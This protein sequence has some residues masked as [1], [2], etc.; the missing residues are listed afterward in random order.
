MN[1][2]SGLLTRLR[3]CL[4]DEKGQALPLCGLGVVAILGFTA[5]AIDV[6]QLRVEKQ[7]MQAA[8]DA[9]ALAGALE[10]SSCGSTTDCTAMTAA[11]KQAVTEN[12]LTVATA[13]TQC[14]GSASGL[15]LWVN[16]GPCELGSSSADPNYGSSKYVEAQL[17]NQVNTVFAGL[18]GFRTMTITVRAEASGA[19]ANYCLIATAD[20]ASPTQGIT[21]QGGSSGGINA[22]NCGIYDDDSSGSN[23]LVDNSGTVTS[24]K[25]MVVGGIQNSGATLSPKP[26]TGASNYADPLS[27]LSSDTPSAGSCTSQSS[28]PA[29]GAALTPG[30]FCSVI[31]LNSNV[32][33][34]L[35]AGTYYLKN[36]INVDSGA[37]LVGTAGVT[38]Y[39]ATGQLNFNSNS[40]VQLTAPTSGT[41]SGIA[42]WQPSSDTNEINLD[43]GSTSAYNGA[44]YAPTAELTLNSASNA[45][46]CTLVDVGSVML[47]SGASFSIGNNCSA[48]S[49]SQA[50]KTGSSAI[51]E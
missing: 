31:T 43:A 34:T 40:T 33:V 36:G 22:P 49:S 1:A 8:V 12:G 16:N 21:L 39:V 14:A 4:V 46:A 51:V 30:T 29:N 7:Q 50:F 48:F 27:Y 18:V 42:I 41:L 19:P 10:I 15:T 28:V 25:F 24:Q 3:E 5:L 35:S 44:I 32:K 37:T 45:A 9:A 17:S 38:L 23:A 11:A 47:D 6:G 13:R 20:S 2:V 26:V